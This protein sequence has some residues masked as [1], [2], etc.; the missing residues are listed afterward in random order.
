MSK[1]RVQVRSW[2]HAVAE[3]RHRYHRP[4]LTPGQGHLLHSAR[5]YLL[6]EGPAGCGAT[7]LL[8][9]KA[10][11]ELERGGC[12]VLVFVPRELTGLR[13][14]YEQFAASLPA[15]VSGLVYFWS[16][17]EGGGGATMGEGR[18]TSLTGETRTLES[19]K[20]EEVNT[21]ALFDRVNR[22]S[23]LSLA[24]G[25]VTDALTSV[26]V[27]TDAPMT[28]KMMSSLPEGKYH[29]VRFSSLTRV[30][31]SVQ[32]L[33]RYGLLGGDE[34]QTTPA[35]STASGGDFPP[36][37]SLSVPTDPQSVAE[38]SCCEGL[39]TDGPTPLFI[40]HPAGTTSAAPDSGILR[41]RLCMTQLRTALRDLV[42][43]FTPRVSVR[44]EQQSDDEAAGRGAATP[45]R[46][47]PVLA[48]PSAT[49]RE[50]TDRAGSTTAAGGGGGSTGVE[51]EEEEEEEEEAEQT[52]VKGEGGGGGGG[53]LDINSGNVPRPL[54]AEEDVVLFADS[55]E[56]VG[57]LVEML[58]LVNAEKVVRPLADLPQLL[59]T[60]RA[61]VGYVGRVKVEAGTD[62]FMHA[63]VSQ[64]CDVM[65]LCQGQLI[66]ALEFT[67]AADRGEP[68]PSSPAGRGMKPAPYQ[69][70]MESMQEHARKRHDHEEGKPKTV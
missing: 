23:D 48:R 9:V 59:G 45:G 54:S 61:V 19:L 50:D 51:E 12:L 3:T 13:R 63:L 57:A 4:V 8:K 41:C 43:D 46:G 67:P 34:E 31:T 44:T 32:V 30:P 26:W 14:D 40:W 28:A 65:T 21:F 11:M 68:E 55:G 7:C 53:G 24:V 20:A 18:F 37:A 49:T 52:P 58:D 38:V 56:D 64:L 62:T 5:P 66:L 29:S 27:V 60:E 39:P 70:D 15:L 1:P 6:L 10:T 22:D 47:R 17:E 33:I 69:L 25:E 35:T 36:T 42:A 16:R 2:A